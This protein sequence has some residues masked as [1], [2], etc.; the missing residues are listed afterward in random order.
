MY[1]RAKRAKDKINKKL[2]NM[3]SA[4]HKKLNAPQD[5]QWLGS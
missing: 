1:R 5:N 2:N 4:S 3:A